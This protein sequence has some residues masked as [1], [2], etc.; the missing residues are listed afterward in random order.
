[1]SA[2]ARASLEMTL[3]KKLI[4]IVAG[5]GLLLVLLAG[6]GNPQ[7]QVEVS[8]PGSSAGAT[9]VAAVAETPSTTAK[10]DDTVPLSG[11]PTVGESSPPMSGPIKMD[12]VVYDDS[13]YQNVGCGSGF[14]WVFDLNRAYDKLSAVIGLDD[15]SLSND[16]VTVTFKGDND[17]NLGTVQ[18]GLGQVKPTDVVTAGNLRLRV[19]VTRSGGGC[20]AET[21]YGSTL[22]LG[23]AVLTP[24]K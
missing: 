20:I 6:C 12:T 1:M 14:T 8:S 24:K 18:T 17:A 4:R 21:G 22:G 10:K 3:M 9:K 15:S 23:N 13:V 19:E 2:T 16:Q 7:Q 11:I 5:P